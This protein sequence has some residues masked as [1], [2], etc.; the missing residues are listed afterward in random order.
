MGKSMGWSIIGKILPRFLLISELVIL[1]SSVITEEIYYD[2]PKIS[3]ISMISMFGGSDCL[4]YW[5]VDGL[6]YV[7]LT[8]RQTESPTLRR[9]LLF[10]CSLFYN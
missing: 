4:R 9:G 5:L 3:M 2:I 8:L 7:R 6:V 10:Y 1:N